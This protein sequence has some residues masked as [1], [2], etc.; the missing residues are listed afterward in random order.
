MNPTHCWMLVILATAAVA[1]PQSEV[2]PAAQDPEP[3][4]EQLSE[5]KAADEQPI[6]VP[7]VAPAVKLAD[8]AMVN[9]HPV[10]VDEYAARRKRQF[11]EVDV[12]VD[13]INNN[14]GFGGPGFNRGYPEYGNGGFGGYGDYGNGGF[15]RDY[16]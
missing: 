4:P 6:Q 5:Q 9:E 10:N 16:Y 8:L 7:A 13:V 1:L 15:G 14:G 3:V 2:V 12:N 11:E